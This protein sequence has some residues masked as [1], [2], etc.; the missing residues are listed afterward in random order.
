MKRVI[1]LIIVILIILGG[2]HSYFSWKNKT[3]ETN[4]ITL[5]GNVDVRQVDLGFR[6]SGRI[7]EMFY[8]EGDFVHPGTLLAYLDDQPFED[9]VKQAEAHVESIGAALINSEQLLERRKELLGTGGISEQDYDDAIS[10]RNIHKANYQEAIAA[11]GV[12]ITNREDTVLF[13][14]SEGTILT[15]IREPGTIVREANPIYTLSLINPIW[16][17]A[18]VSEVQ[19]GNIFPGMQAEIYTDTPKKNPYRG[20]IGFI[21]PV[22]EFTPKTVETTSLRTDLVYRLRIIVDNVDY[23]LRQGMPVTVKLR[24]AEQEN[25][26]ANNELHDNP[27]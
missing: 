19:L 21:S 5:Y 9:Q 10:S 12:A 18:Y 26:H 24:L 20:H 3:Q 2:Y 16:V 25:V 8:E 27:L 11:L 14:P 7:A 4:F 1:L 22:A 13:A 6:V 15:R 17:R 23:G